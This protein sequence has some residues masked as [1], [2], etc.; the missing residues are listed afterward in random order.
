M[1]AIGFSLQT[2]VKLS[3]LLSVKVN[4]CETYNIGGHNEMKNIDIVTTI[5]KIL[6]ELEPSPTL[7]S[8]TELITYVKDRPGHDLRYAI[9]RRQN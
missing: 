5:C 6:D 4:F 3:I 8:Y 2:T 7:N 9:D 1:C